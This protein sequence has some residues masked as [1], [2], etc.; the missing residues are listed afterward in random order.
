MPIE[1][2]HVNGLFCPFSQIPQERLCLFSQ[3]E[4]I[5]ELIAKFNEP[6]TQKVVP[7]LWILPDITEIAKG[8]EESVDRLLWEV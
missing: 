4:L 2:D 3:I 8:R 1:E 7:C 6:E 5:E